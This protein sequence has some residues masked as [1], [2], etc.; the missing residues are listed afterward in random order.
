MKLYFWSLQ[1]SKG[2]NRGLC[3]RRGHGSCQRL[4][5]PMIVP[6]TLLTREGQLFCQNNNNVFQT[7]GIVYQQF[8][9]WTLK[10]EPLNRILT[11]QVPCTACLVTGNHEKCRLFQMCARRLFQ[12]FARRLFQMCARRLFQM[13]ARRLFQMCARRQRRIRVKTVQCAPRFQTTTT[14]VIVT[15]Q[16]S[17]EDTVISK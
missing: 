4:S 6:Y 8:C 2:K 9:L 3:W 14:C 13:C 11:F 15:A 5:P 16:V 17:L 1:W 7:L 12:M 10:P